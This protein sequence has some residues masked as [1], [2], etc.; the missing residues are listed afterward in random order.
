MERIAT[1]ARMD[2]SNIDGYRQSSQPEPRHTSN[3]GELDGILFRFLI[4]S[5]KT[6]VGGAMYTNAC[7]V[8]SQQ[9]PSDKG[10]DG[11]QPVGV[12]TATV[13]AMLWMLRL[14][15]LEDSFSDIPLNVD[16]ISVE[17]MEW[18]SEQH[19]KWLSV[20]QFTVVGTMI[21]WMAY[22]RGFRNK[23]MATPTVRWTDDYEALIH[24]GQHV[25]VHEFQRAAYRIKL[26][27]DQVMQTLFGGQWSTIGPNI[28]LQSIQ[29]DMTYLGA[30]QSFA[31][32]QA[33]AWLRSGPELA[34]KAAQSMLFYTG[35]NEWRSK[36]VTR[37]LSNLRQLKGLLM[38]GKHVWTGMPGRGPEVSTLRHCDGLQVMRNVFL[39]E[40]SV[41]I[42]T[43]LLL[44][45]IS[46]RNANRWARLD[47]QH[48]I[49]RR[50][51]SDEYGIQQQNDPDRVRGR[52]MAHVRLFSI[53]T[54]AIQQERPRLL[55][56]RFSTAISTESAQK[57]PDKEEGAKRIQAWLTDKPAGLIVFSDGS[58]T[59]R[60]TA[61]YG[62]V[63][64]RNGQLIDSG[65]NQLSKREVFDAEVTGALQGLRSAI[66]HRQPHEK[67]TICIDN[68]SV[69]DG[70][71]ST[72]PMSS[73]ADFRTLQKTGDLN[74]GMISVRWCPGHSGIHG[75]E[76]A[77]QLAKE[78]AQLSPTDLLPSVEAHQGPPGRPPSSNGGARSV[79]RPTRILASRLCNHESAIGFAIFY[80]FSKICSELVVVFFFF[81]LDQSIN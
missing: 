21:N 55:P 42:A 22:G 20:D 11:F 8:S 60:D 30:G 32:N 46:E 6:K 4:P 12:F 50:L 33:N 35:K 37:W 26:K 77:D 2:D 57:R 73:Q 74:P 62:F 67:I 41:M 44:Q 69:I 75:N 80:A 39:Y 79:G 56:L 68:T 43:D 48:P 24:N 78:G 14:F 61:G 23:T 63:V 1:K 47:V 25:R 15:F 64:F 72:A 31:T 59:E 5:I 28:D 9:Q 16:D 29:D 49:T 38:V 18:F 65:K 34:I 36:G 71:G 53:A 70:I 3:H 10:G 27:A 17:K 58:K 51:T 13:A 45:Q 54:T 76:R 7:F 52:T 19:A 40:G 66:S 81:K